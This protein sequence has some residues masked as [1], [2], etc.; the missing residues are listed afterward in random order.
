MRRRRRRRRN[1]PDAGV[2]AALSKLKLLTVP[3]FS[4]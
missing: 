2:G 4:V 1:I 3:L